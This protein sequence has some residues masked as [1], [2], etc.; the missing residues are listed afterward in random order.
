MPDHPGVENVAVDTRDLYEQAEERL[1]GIITRQL[2]DG[3]A[4]HGWAERELAAA[5]ALRRAPR[6]PSTWW[7]TN[8]RP[9]G[10]SS[11]TR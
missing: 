10:P 4:A 7:A 2:A 11:L 6:R 9:T 1:L 8:G 5:P 3:L